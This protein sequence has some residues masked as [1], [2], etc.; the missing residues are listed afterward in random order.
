[1]C[2]DITV[3]KNISWMSGIRTSYRQKIRNSN[4]S[5]IKEH[6]LSYCKIFSDVIK[7]AK[8]LSCDTQIINLKNNAWEIVKLEMGTKANNDNIHPLNLGGRMIS[9]QQGTFENNFLSIADNINVNNTYSNVNSHKLI[10]V[11][12]NLYHKFL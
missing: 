2:T 4:N 9:K 11:P 8:S 10:I 1:M 5:T 6:Y 3:A 7:E 12:C